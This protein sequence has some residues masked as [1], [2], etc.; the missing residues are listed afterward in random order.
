MYLNNKHPQH[1][2]SSSHKQFKWIRLL[3]PMMMIASGRTTGSAVPRTTMPAM[4][5]NLDRRGREPGRGGRV[6]SLAARGGRA[7]QGQGRIPVP[8]LVLIRL[9]PFAAFGRKDPTV[10][11]NPIVPGDAIVPERVSQAPRPVAL[12][13]RP[14]RAKRRGLLARRVH[15]GLSRAP[16]RSNRGAGV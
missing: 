6:P 2:N 8:L 7:R 4:V 10:P 12:R 13:Q 9:R 11:E 16:R 15:P 1:N 3:S 5:R 14:T